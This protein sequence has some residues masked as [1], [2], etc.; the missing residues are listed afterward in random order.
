MCIFQIVK[1]KLIQKLSYM[2]KLPKGFNF[3]ISQEFVLEIGY[4]HYSDIHE[5]TS[6]LTLTT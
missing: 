4:L 5:E 2:N 1:L 3:V 6:F